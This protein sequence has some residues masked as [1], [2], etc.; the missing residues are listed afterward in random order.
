MSHVLA[1]WEVL[2]VL[3]ILTTLSL[4]YMQKAYPNYYYFC[5]ITTEMQIRVC[6]RNFYIQLYWDLVYRR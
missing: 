1:T 3:D 6:K 2:V 4:P 5:D